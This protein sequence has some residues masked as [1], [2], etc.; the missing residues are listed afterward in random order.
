MKSY[1]WIL[2]N[3]IAKDPNPTLAIDVSLLYLMNGDIY[4]SAKYLVYARQL[5]E[6]IKM[7]N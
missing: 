1:S 3:S 5:H 2:L 4:H 6:R 7:A